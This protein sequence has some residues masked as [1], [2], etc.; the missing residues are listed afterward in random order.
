MTTDIRVA[1]QQLR[2]PR[3]AERYLALQRTAYQHPINRVFRRLRLGKLYD[4]YILPRLEGLRSSELSA[5]YQRDLEAEYRSIADALPP[6]ASDVLDIGC[7]LA[8]IDLYLYLH[9]HAQIN[10]HLLD[11]DGISDIYYGFNSKGAFYNSLAVARSLLQDNGVAARHV[12]T[13][14]VMRDRFPSAPQFQLV[15]SLISWGYH[16]P[17]STYVSEVRAQLVAGGTLIVDVRRGTTGRAELEEAFQTRAV[18]LKQEVKYERLKL[19]KGQPGV[20]PA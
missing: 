1:V 3:G 20:S 10:L 4:S 13:Y 14:E 18:C 8:G 11:R 2:V 12:H 6:A 9:Y 7:G 19:V 5:C 15:L 17:I 16:Y